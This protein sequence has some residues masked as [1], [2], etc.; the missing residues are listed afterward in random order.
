MQC[1]MKV[2]HIY[3][4]V[5]NMR[6]AMPNEHPDISRSPNVP[7]EILTQWP[8]HIKLNSSQNKIEVTTTLGLRRPVIQK[9]FQAK[10]ATFT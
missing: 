9:P 2:H 5:T 3:S 1:T 10:G 7:L 6:R 4:R 8:G